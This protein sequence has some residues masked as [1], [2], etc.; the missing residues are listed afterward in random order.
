MPYK[1]LYI[2][3]LSP[4]YKCEGYTAA[5]GRTGSFFSS[6][7]SSSISLRYLFALYLFL[8]GTGSPVSSLELSI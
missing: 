5:L 8:V 2:V 1:F 3:D 4:G 7:F 6:I